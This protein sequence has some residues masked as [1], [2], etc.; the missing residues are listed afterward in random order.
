MK[1][2]NIQKPRGKK[3]YN[4]EDLSALPL[5]DKGEIHVP[6]GGILMGPD[7]AWWIDEDGNA[8]FGGEMTVCKDVDPEYC[9]LDNQTSA[10]GAPNRSLVVV[11]QSLQYKDSGGSATDV[12]LGTTSAG[13][14]PATVE[15]INNN[16]D[17]GESLTPGFSAS[18]TVTINVSSGNPDVLLLAFFTGSDETG[19]VVPGIRIRRT[20]ATA[21]T[22]AQW[23]GSSVSTSIPTYWGGCMFGIDTSVSSGN[24]T[25]T[26]DFDE[27]GGSCFALHSSL[28][29]FECKTADA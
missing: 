7:G 24:K 16:A 14:H 6:D 25:Y 2:K 8:Y 29:A 13:D 10:S 1:K 22:L 9:Q 11:N 27:I 17:P 19:G 3:V 12:P 21:T 18:N 28:V 15:D 20:T 23:T 26:L 4:V 5:N